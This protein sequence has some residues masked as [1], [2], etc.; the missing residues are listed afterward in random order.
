MNI[1][2]ELRRAAVA[3]ELYEAWYEVRPGVKAP[4]LDGSTGE[5]CMF[6]REEVM[7]AQHVMQGFRVGSVKSLAR[8]A[9]V[10]AYEGKWLHVR[11]SVGQ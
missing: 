9:D 11:R 8:F 1:V 7:N 3:N 5:A 6:T 10:M 2:I 4:L